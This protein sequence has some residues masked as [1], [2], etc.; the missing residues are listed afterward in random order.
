MAILSIPLIDKLGNKSLNFSPL[1]YSISK[2][3]IPFFLEMDKEIPPYTEAIAM[4]YGWMWKIPTQDRY[5]CGYVYDSNYI[6][7]DD[8]IK[9]IENYLGFEPQYP[10]K[11]KGAFSFSAGCFE[12]I[13][14]K[15][16]LSVGLSAGFLE[17]LEA[18]SIMQTIFALKRFMSDKQNLYTNDRIRKIFY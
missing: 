14:I 11:E 5:G 8:A 12:D 17:P 9:E 7:D 3:A 13:W 16:C 18:T 6:S 1:A 2:K 15:N 10:R 4:D